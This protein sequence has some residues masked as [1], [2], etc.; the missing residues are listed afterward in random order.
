MDSE[1][2][3]Y[4]ASLHGL[5]DLPKWIKL[6]YNPIL[7]MGFLYGTPLPNFKSTIKVLYMNFYLNLYSM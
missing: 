3:S 7:K 6:T 2:Y 5:P 1:S 4:S